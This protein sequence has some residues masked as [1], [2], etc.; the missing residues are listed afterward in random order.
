MD[1]RICGAG[2]QPVISFGRMP[3]ANAFL[4]REEFKDEYFFD[5]AVGFCPDCT[6]VQLLEQPAPEMMFHDH[7]AYFSSISRRMAAHF[8][9]FAA[10]VR[11]RHLER[12]N[13][14]VVEIGSNDGIMLQHFASADIRHLGIEPSA[15]VA[16]AAREKGVNTIC[17]FFGPGLAARIL[18]EQGPADAILAANVMC[19]IPD[20]HA[21]GAGVARL[22]SPRGVLVFEDPYLGEILTKTSYDQIY[23]EHAFYFSATSVSRVFA[24]HGLELI[25]AQPQ[26]VHG[27]SMRYTFARA[28]AFPAGP[29]VAARLQQEREMGLHEGAVFTDFRT[30]VEQSRNNLQALLT[31]LR[32]EGKR[33]VGYGATSKSTTVNVFCGITP[34]LVEFV[35]DTTPTKQGRYTPGQH[36]PVKSYEEFAVDFPDVALLYAWNHGR[37]IMEKESAFRRAGGRW[38][39]Y[40]PTVEIIA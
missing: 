35:S 40:V 31:R 39:V 15:N 37:E 38:L 19:H 18:E 3:I 30:R 32:T 9:D 29:A 13:P 11:R 12:Q 20:L 33:V 10:Q 23:D 34:D 27:G 25:D 28:G 8:A 24:E 5:L 7:Y 2:L 26:P 1:C 6:M 16:A 17:E 36:I 21:V 22:L 4:T 14:F